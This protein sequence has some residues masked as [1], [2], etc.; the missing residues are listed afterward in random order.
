MY[1]KENEEIILK[2]KKMKVIKYT[3]NFLPIESD[4]L[5]VRKVEDT[6]EEVITKI[7][8]TQTKM[9][10]MNIFELP[11]GKGTI[12]CAFFTYNLSFFL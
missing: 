4:L 2:G 10:L 7:T 5:S 1:Q 3:S 8:D 9:V 11:F 12:C 6:Q